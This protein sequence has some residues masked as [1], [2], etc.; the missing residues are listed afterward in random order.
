MTR[1]KHPNKEIDSAIKYAEE[2]GW[3]IKLSNGYCWGRLLCVTNCANGCKMSIW[4]TPRVPENHARQIRRLVDNCK[5]KK[6]GTK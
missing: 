4:S 5:K 2:N 3:H 1:P 6:R